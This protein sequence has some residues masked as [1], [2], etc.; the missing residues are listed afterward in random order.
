MSVE[1][2]CREHCEAYRPE[3]AESTKPAD[4]EFGDKR[5]ELA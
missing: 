1:D 2:A 5:V 4:P 3:T